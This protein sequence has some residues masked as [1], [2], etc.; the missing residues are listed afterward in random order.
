MNKACP[1]I[2]RESHN[3]R[4]KEV[5]VFRHPL[6][7]N[8]LVKGTIESGETLKNACERELFEESGIKAKSDIY[9]GKW[10]ANFENQIW[11]FYLMTLDESLSELPEQWVHFTEDGGGLEFSFFWIKLDSN[12]I[13]P[14]TDDSFHPVFQRAIS[15]IYSSLLM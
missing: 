3:T 7:G 12:I 8:Q 2:I 9:L 6:A 13:K 15:Y 11:G 4:G 5:L 1:V 14:V 10:N